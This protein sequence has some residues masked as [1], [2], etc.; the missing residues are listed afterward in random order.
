V[1]KRGEIRVA[2]FAHFGQPPCAWGR[3][4]ALHLLVKELLRSGTRLFV[5][6][7][8]SR[9]SDRE[10]VPARVLDYTNVRV[11]QRFHEIIPDLIVPT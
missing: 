3:E 11:E 6:A 5:P 9:Y 4:T 1:A 8:V 10:L 2:H 7:V